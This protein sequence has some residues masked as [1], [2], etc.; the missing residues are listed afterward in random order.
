MNTKLIKA[1]RTIARKPKIYFAGKIGKYDWRTQIF[2]ERFAG[3]CEETKLWDTTHTID[4]GYFFCCG[5]FFVSCDHGCGHVPYAHGCAD[6]CGDGDPLEEVHQRVWFANSQRVR[7][8]DLMFVYIDADDCFGTLIEVGY[9]AAINKPIFIWF[10]DK[11][12]RAQEK[13]LLMV[14][15]P[16]VKTYYGE[17]EAVLNEFSNELLHSQVCA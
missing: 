5:P 9:A 12:T 7:H 11:L 1:P 13:D 16:A 8:C 15:K 3:T 17:P 4:Y 6:N 10:S 14:F 2:G